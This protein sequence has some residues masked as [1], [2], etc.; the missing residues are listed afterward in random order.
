MSLT[1][2]TGRHT[3]EP[4][5]ELR[6]EH[7]TMTKRL[8]RL[9]Q[10]AANTPPR[11]QSWAL[12]SEIEVLRANIASLERRYC[13]DSVVDGGIVPQTPLGDA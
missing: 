13:F 11:R 12:K 1:S 10:M 5:T 4:S 2:R 8:G 9:K 7:R 3:T 6:E